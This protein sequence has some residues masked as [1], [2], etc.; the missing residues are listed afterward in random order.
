MP[1]TRYTWSF[2]GEAIACTKSGIEIFSDM[3]TLFDAF[4]DMSVKAAL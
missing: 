1:A 2:I 4:S 3:P